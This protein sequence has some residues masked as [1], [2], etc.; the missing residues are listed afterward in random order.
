MADGVNKKLFK[1]AL[2]ARGVIMTVFRKRP[3]M[4]KLGARLFEW[5]R[6]CALYK[7]NKA[8]GTLLDVSELKAKWTCEDEI[9]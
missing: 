7:F 2:G 5:M 6:D 8:N 3:F 4:Y 1:C 9:E